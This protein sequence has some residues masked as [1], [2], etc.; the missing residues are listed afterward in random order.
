MEPYLD[1]S[2]IPT[3]KR[4]ESVVISSNENAS[5]SPG[6][7]ETRRTPSHAIVDF[8]GN[9][10]VVRAQHLVRPR[11][12]RQ[13][14]AFWAHTLALMMA[15]ISGLVM[16]IVRGTSSVEFG[17]WSGIFSFGVGGFLPNPKLKNDQPSG[18]ATPR[19]Q[20]PPV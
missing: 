16:M 8:D 20:H 12:G 3:F 18:G 11:C 6:K 15:A 13:S 7:T 17:F 1:R 4:S 10:Q 19:Q 9:I 2:T 14:L 5:E